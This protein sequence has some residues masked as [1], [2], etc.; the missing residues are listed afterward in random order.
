MYQHE[1]SD[2]M[3][4]KD[5]ATQKNENTVEYSD[6]SGEKTSVAW[7]QRIENF[8]YH[9]KFQTIAGAFLIFVLA[10]TV[11]TSIGKNTED[12]Y[13]GYIGDYSYS[14][15]EQN[16]KSEKITNALNI[17][18]RGNGKSE[19]AF[20]SKVYMSDEQLLE[21]AKEAEKR[22]DVY[23]F[24]PARNESNFQNFIT[25]LENGDT[26]VWI[27]SHEV[28]ERMD[29]TVLMPLDEILGEESAAAVDEY[30]LDCSKLDFGKKMI[31]EQCYGSYLIMR[32][33]RQYS[34]I[35]GTE[36]MNLQE[37]R[38]KQLFKSIIDYKG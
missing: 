35:M 26:A 4:N 16:E 28:Y 33:A 34:S 3:E 30:A 32:G 24:S 17:D 7:R 9:Y 21:K 11:I 38:D 10:W 13:I 23:E 27:V 29:K 37:E 14:M 12:A 25:E 2:V 1:K 36:E 19:I 18:L 20:H 22:G 15:N 5:K 8:F 31:R 6:K